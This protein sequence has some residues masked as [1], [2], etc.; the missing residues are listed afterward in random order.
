MIN[1]I[2]FK[3]ENLFCLFLFL[4]GICLLSICP[5][6]A[7]EAAK[8]KEAKFYPIPEKASEPFEISPEFREKKEEIEPP[9]IEVTGIMETDRGI[10]AI[11]ELDLENYEGTAILKPGQ[12]VS[13]P[14]PKSSV[15]DKWISYFT[16]KEITRH[17]IVIVL[18]NGKKAYFPVLSSRD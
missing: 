10:V 12:R 15:A 9:E 18:E 17:G 6:F 13:M 16:V 11:V 8:E 4:L 1:K 3:I 7:E 2:I 5:V 14:D